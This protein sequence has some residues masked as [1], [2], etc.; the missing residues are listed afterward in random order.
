MA[1]FK[2]DIN[3]EN[4]RT[5]F[6]S[7]FIEEYKILKINVNGFSDPLVDIEGNVYKTVWIGKQLWMAENLKSTKYNDGTPVPL[8]QDAFSS[9]S[10]SSL[11]PGYCYYNND[12][13]NKNIYGALYQWGVVEKQK[14]CPVGWSVPS[15]YDFY[16][17]TGYLGKDDFLAEK[18][19]DSLTWK[20]SEYFKAT[21]WSLFSALP[22]GYRGED[23]SGLSINT[24]FWSS[25]RGKILNT[26]NPK[27]FI[28]H[29]NTGYFSASLNNSDE[30]F[31]YIRCIK[32]QPNN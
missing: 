18:L 10:Y 32:T 11:Y 4:G 13:N 2:I 25:S 9:Y 28:M 17:L 27:V 24:G 7:N 8:N 21:N 15:D 20:K 29:Y 23:F 5:A 3:N 19:K 31:Y 16:T 12:A 22:G 14:V 26:T 6:N 30:Y 1:K